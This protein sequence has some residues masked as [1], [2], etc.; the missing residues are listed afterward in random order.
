MC[1][2]SA[3]KQNGNQ[4]AAQ[5]QKT[6]AMETV[7]D[8]KATTGLLAATSSYN[9]AKPRDPNGVPAIR[10]PQQKGITRYFHPLP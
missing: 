2:H 6:S 5:V 9:L 8:G 7:I 10:K 1:V 4:E 3:N